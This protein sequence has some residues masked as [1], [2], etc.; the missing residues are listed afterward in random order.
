MRLLPPVNVNNMKLSTEELTD[1]TDT[2]ELVRVHTSEQA[3]LGL[4][5]AVTLF[6]NDIGLIILLLSTSLSSSVKWGGNRTSPQDI[7]D[8][9]N[10]CES[11]G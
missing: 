7:K 1:L 10:S 4:N 3:C 5:L 9:V 6:T 8:K 2:A 11:L